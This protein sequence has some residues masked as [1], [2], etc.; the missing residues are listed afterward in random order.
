MWITGAEPGDVIGE[1]RGQASVGAVVQYWLL[2]HGGTV[3]IRCKRNRSIVECSIPMTPSSQLNRVASASEMQPQPSSFGDQC[4]D[5][6][7]FA[8]HPGE[9][10][11]YRSYSARFLR[12]LVDLAPMD[13]RCIGG[14]DPSS[15]YRFPFGVAFERMKTSTKTS[16]ASDR[17][18]NPQ[19][20]GCTPS[21]YFVT[22][23]PGPSTTDYS[24]TRSLAYLPNS[25][26]GSVKRNVAP[27]PW[28]FSAHNR[29][30]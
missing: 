26:P 24:I 11:E 14:V 18:A 3:W 16:R 8:S 5:L 13:L 25:A 30:P 6:R 7:S 10:Q 15:E 2:V 29:P 22:L 9:R 1:R 19:N 23:L 27:A 4:C 12:D 20:S 17:P 21:S 28:L